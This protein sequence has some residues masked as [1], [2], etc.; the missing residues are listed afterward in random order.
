MPKKLTK[1]DKFMNAVEKSGKVKGLSLVILR[2]LALQPSGS[3]PSQITEALKGAKRSSVSKRLSDLAD[4]QL[5]VPGKKVVCPVSGRPSTKW[6]IS[7]RVDV[8]HIAE[9]KF[10]KNNTDAAY[11]RRMA[12]YNIS[13]NLATYTQTASDNEKEKLNRLLGFDL[14]VFSEA[15]VPGADHSLV[16]TLQSNSSMYYDLAWHL[17]DFCEPDSL[18][19][20]YLALNPEVGHDAALYLAKR[21]HAGSR[22]HANL[23]SNL[24]IGDRAAAYLSSV[25]Q[26]N[27][28]VHVL[29]A[30]NP[31]LDM[32]ELAYLFNNNE[33]NSDVHVALAGNPKIGGTYM[34]EQLY[35]AH[36]PGSRVYE[37]LLA[38]PSIP[39]EVAEII[40]NTT[41]RTVQDGTLLVETIRDELIKESDTQAVLAT[42]WPDW[43]EVDTTEEKV[44]AAWLEIHSID[45][46]LKVALNRPWYWRLFA[47]RSKVAK[48]AKYIAELRDIRDELHNTIM[49]LGGK[50]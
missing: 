41:E 18:V 8:E 12:E 47:S 49:A 24:R 15:A 38:N 1:K 44:K 32:F 46:R 45:D 22:V 21:N 37:A 13:L 3:T 40:E 25:N 5:V 42:E 14:D 6:K 2:H 36:N 20:I 48:N 34:V 16:Q 7:G 50:A 4:W 23:A 17:T 10:E 31:N 35:M 29:L 33:P 28:L 26:S 30:A 9:V 19:H 39:P 11:R 43:Q 27:S